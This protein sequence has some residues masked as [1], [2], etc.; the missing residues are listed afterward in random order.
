MNN[1]NLIKWCAVAGVLVSLNACSNTIATDDYQEAPESSSSTTNSCKSL[2]ETLA[3]PTNFNVNRDNDTTWTLSWDYT[4]N[5][6]R[7]EESFQIESLNMDSK[8]PTWKKEGT[9][10]ADVTLYKL[11]GKSKVGKYYRVY[12]VDECGNSKASNRLQINSNGSTEVE[13]VT[14]SETVKLAAPTNF[15][16]T[17]TLGTNRWLLSWSYSGDN[18]GY[19]LQRFI[20]KSSKWEQFLKVSDPTALETVVDTNAAGKYV[21]IAATYKGSVSTYSS[22]IKIP[23][24]VSTSTGSSSTSSGT[25]SNC[26]G[27]LAAPT[28]LA[29]MRIAPSVWRLSWDYKKTSTCPETGFLVQKLDLKADEPKWEKAGNSAEDVYR[30]VLNGD[31]Y[32]GLMYR[33]VALNGDKKSEWSNQIEVTTETSYSTEF[34]FTTPELLASIYKAAGGYDMRLVVTKNFPNEAMVS[35]SY[36]KKLEYEFRWGGSAS[37]T[38]IIDASDASVKQHFTDKENLCSSY[39]EVRIIWTDVNDK[40]DVTEWSTRVGTLAGYNKNLGDSEKLCPYVYEDEEAGG[41]E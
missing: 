4:R 39:G 36:T 16:V 6:S 7:P 24:A 30:F 23:N 33:V 41:E 5:D 28:N 20:D 8:D 3:A 22:K 27:T 17:D 32:R 18:D 29:A 34:S 12:A 40:T 35:S 19:V 26:S 37:G 11:K 25:K 10:R 14:T 15:A 38:E 13:V 31:K 21:R 9:T 1:L 2:G